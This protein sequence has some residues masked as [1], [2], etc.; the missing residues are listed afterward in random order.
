MGTT[1]VADILSWAHGLWYDDLY[2][3]WIITD[4]INTLQGVFIWLV[5]GCQPQVRN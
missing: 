5:V 1:W 3:V 4:L 2:Y